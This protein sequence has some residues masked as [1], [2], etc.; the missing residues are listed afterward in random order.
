VRWKWIE[1]NPALLIKNP[2]PKPGEIHPFESW[3][4]LDVIADELT[5]GSGVLVIF[6]AGTGV[7]PEEAFGGEWRDVDLGR[8]VF[9]VRRAFAKGRKKDYTRTTGSRRAVP[10]RARV[11]AALELSA[12]GAG[13]CSLRRST[14]GSTSTTSVTGSGRR[15][16]RRPGLPTGVS[17]TCATPTRLGA[18]RRP[19]TSSLWRGGWAR[20]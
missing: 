17:V 6:L 12:H 8:H 13:S 14:V 7:R 5:D 11:I 16:W 2:A 18:C 3:D 1:D 15:R 20:A 9:M 19:W 4:E 10:L